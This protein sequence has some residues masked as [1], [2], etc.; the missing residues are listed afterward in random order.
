MNFQFGVGVWR[1]KSGVGKGELVEDYLMIGYFVI[2]EVNK[3]EF[4][5]SFCS[6]I[7]YLLLYIILKFY[8]SIVS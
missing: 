7:G 4:C 5:I 1:Q 8:Y 3:S 2:V 6:R